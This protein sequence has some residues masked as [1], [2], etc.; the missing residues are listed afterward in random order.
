MCCSPLPV[1]PFLLS[2][3]S[4][5]WEGYPIG[6]K[7]KSPRY[8]LPLSSPF[9]MIFHQNAMISNDPRPSLSRQQNLATKIFKCPFTFL[10]H[11]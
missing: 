5:P 8:D 11:P 7:P 3:P 9:L 10:R 4:C 6:S 2:S 1:F